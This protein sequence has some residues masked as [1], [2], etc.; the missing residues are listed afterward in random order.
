MY[1]HMNEATPP[2]KR[3]RP[4]NGAPYSRRSIALRLPEPYMSETMRLA[5]DEASTEANF[6]R[7]V[8]LIGL[9]QYRKRVKARAATQQEQAV[10]A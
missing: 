5:A 3:G 9:A 6:A 8:Y 7:R 1:H 4:V 10:Q 2:R